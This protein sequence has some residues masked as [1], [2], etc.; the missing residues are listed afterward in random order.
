MASPASTTQRQ[1]AVKHLQEL[2]TVV[3]GLALTT[4]I[5]KLIDQHASIL[6]STTVAPYFAAYFCTLVPI[7]HGA[8]C[9]FDRTYLRE[10]HP[11]PKPGALLVDWVLLFI[12]SCGLLGLALLVQTP[13][14]FCLGLLALL[15]F[16]AVW[17]L[18]AHFAFSSEKR[19]LTIEVKWALINFI[20]SFL[21]I[22][23]LVYLDS[24]DH[25]QKPVE[26]Y[27]WVLVLILTIA[28]TIADYAWCWD[29]YF[30]REDEAG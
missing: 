4:A 10:P 5:T 29:G 28:R 19:G 1:R 30:P 22:C 18:G 8:L 2:Y 7:Y 23:A 26:F 9:H 25:T 6:V 16:D 24:L 17:G 13:V 21:L 15:L 20:A 14:S 12:E 27:R 3:T 11:T